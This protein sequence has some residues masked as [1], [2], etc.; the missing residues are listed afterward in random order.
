LILK[1]TI[2]YLKKSSPPFFDSPSPGLLRK[3]GE[4]ES[5]H[6]ETR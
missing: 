3:P 1:E 6:Q 4:G 5:V 2:F